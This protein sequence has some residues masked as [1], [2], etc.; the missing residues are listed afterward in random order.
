MAAIEAIAAAPDGSYVTTYQ[1]RRIVMTSEQAQKVRSAAAQ[2]MQAAVNRSRRRL[3]D[4]VGRYRA[5]ESVNKEFW[6][7]SHSVKAYAYIRTL[8]DYSDPGFAIAMQQTGFNVAAAA[9]QQSIQT[10]ALVKAAGALAQADSASERTAKLVRV[11][12]DQLIEGGESLATGLEYTRDAAFIT[13]GVLAIVATG[14]A[15]AGA[16]PGVVG[17]G[18]GGLSVGATA[19]TISVAAP[20][21]ANVGV[22]LMKV[23]DGEPVDWGSIAVDAA[24]Q[25][26]LARFG[27]KLG[28]S[29][30]G[31]VAGSA[32]SRTLA[33]KAM[34]SVVS[35]VATHEVGQAF[36]VSVQHAYSALRGQPVTW[37][38]FIDDLTTRLADPKGLFIAAAM[39]SIQFGAHAAVDRHLAAATPSA[40]RRPV[41]RS[42]TAKPAPAPK[43]PAPEHAPAA[44]SAAV[45]EH[46]PAAP[47]TAVP[48]HA[49]AAP[50]AAKVAEGMDTDRAFAELKSELGPEVA[51]TGP[52]M[53]Q[54]LGARSPGDPEPEPVP[55]LPE[56]FAVSPTEKA[57]LEASLQVQRRKD[58]LDALKD[59]PDLQAALTSSTKK[60]GGKADLVDLAADSPSQMR[61][62][63][64]DWKVN[65]AKRT[66]EGKT[67]HEFADYVKSRQ[68]EA[69]GIH[70]ERTDVFARGASEIIVQA[71]GRVNEEGIDSVSFAPGPSGGRIKLLDNKALR[72][73]A[74]VGKVSALQQNLPARAA[75]GATPAKAGNL[76]D[77]IAIVQNAASQPEAPPAIKDVVLP[78]LQAASKA[79]NDHVATW[80]NAN[81][82]KPLTDRQLQTEIGTILDKYGIDRVVTTA[83]GGSNVK[84]SG[85]LKKQGFTQ[86]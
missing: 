65:S 53:G 4:A 38:R 27:G 64:E 55:P 24:V 13:L 60:L 30:F 29:V 18:I 25:V 47:S 71:P 40:G 7:T 20:I 37:A 1:G 76:D 70:G 48:E 22:G 61:K 46:A 26:L 43:A 77:A 9:A 59:A 79:I 15:A 14:G 72:E 31:K 80:Q 32:V 84:I 5:Q 11:Y 52:V 10:G 16:A 62:L 23:A 78:R 6:F 21:L 82:G 58:A 44:P 36:S 75:S 8:G 66:A 19:T 54:K 12:V 51:A 39:S 85:P 69:R 74:R 41:A 35:G 57:E 3:D 49:P 2:A 86:E 68:T 50:S 56:K 34:A 63:W 42:Q 33:R 81:P 28:E 83:G 45:P 73:G 67:P 17:T